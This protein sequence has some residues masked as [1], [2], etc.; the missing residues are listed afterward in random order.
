MG[1]AKSFIGING[2]QIEYWTIGYYR[3]DRRKKFVECKMY[4][5]AS[6]EDSKTKDSPLFMKAVRIT[7]DKYDSEF[8]SVIKGSSLN[9]MQAI[10]GLAKKYDEFFIDAENVIDPEDSVINVIETEAFSGA[11]PVIETTESEER[12]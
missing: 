5:F 11:E 4:G 10:Y 1:L 3:I 6:E 8:D 12:P 2:A 9:V 7:A